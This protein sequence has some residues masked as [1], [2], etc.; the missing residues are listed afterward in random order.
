MIRN[1]ALIASAFAVISLLSTAEGRSP[2]GTWRGT[3][4]CVTEAVSCHDEEVVYYISMVPNRSDEFSI[5]A[6][7]IVNGM[8]V[9]MGTG[10]WTYDPTKQTLSLDSNG[11]L[12]LLTI[13]GNHI[14]GTLKVNRSTI[15]RRMALTF[16]SQTGPVSGIR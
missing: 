16:D 2:V 6:D 12:W 1:G 7:K 5:R 13:R 11:R 14:E 8:A 4:K 15:F 10:T 3:S 9:T